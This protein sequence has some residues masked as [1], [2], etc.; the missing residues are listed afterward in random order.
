MHKPDS[1]TDNERQKILLDLEIQTYHPILARWPDLVLIN[2]KKIICHLVD[3]AV[4]VDHRGKMK[5]SKKKDKYLELAKEQKNCG[6][7]G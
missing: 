4:P 6:I 2:K 1:I 3:F 7:W 5:E